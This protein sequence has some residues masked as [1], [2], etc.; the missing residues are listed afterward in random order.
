MVGNWNP[1]DLQVS[2]WLRDNLEGEKGR[3]PKNELI[4]NQV[5][6]FVELI[7]SAT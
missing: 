1:N 4:W 2:H 7:F 3:K 5:I 6:V